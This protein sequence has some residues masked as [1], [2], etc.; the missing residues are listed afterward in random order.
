MLATGIPYI[1]AERDRDVEAVRHNFGTDAAFALMRLS[2]ILIN[3]NLDG[4]ECFI[5]RLQHK[6]R[7]PCLGAICPLAAV[8]LPPLSR[9]D[10][11]VLMIIP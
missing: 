10:L 9:V 8:V 5:D 7:T 2:L 3:A 4:A 11:E 1:M 6:I